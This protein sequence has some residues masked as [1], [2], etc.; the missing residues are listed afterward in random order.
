MYKN[1]CIIFTLFLFFNLSDG[2]R[3]SRT[4]NTPRWAMGYGGALFT[5]G[6][7]IRVGAGMF[8]SDYGY[9]IF[10]P[11]T[12][13]WTF[14]AR[15]GFGDHTTSILLPNGKLLHTTTGGTMYLYEPTTDIWTTSGASYS[16][17]PKNPVT[18]LKDGRILLTGTNSYLYNYIGDNVSATAS[19][20]DV[21]MGTETLLP[22]DNVLVVIGTTAKLYSPTAGTWTNTASPLVGRTYH[23]AV[24]L[25]PPYSKVL[26]ISG[27][28]A[29]TS[30]TLYD[31]VTGTWGATG[32]LNYGA[33]VVSETVLLP[34]GKVLIISSDSTNGGGPGS[35]KTCELFD[36]A[37]GTSGTWSMTDSL[38][39]PIY[40]FGGASHSTAFILQTG[41]VLLAGCG[42]G[43]VQ[44]PPKA[45]LIYDPS[46]AVFR[47]RPVLNYA[48]DA[49]TTTPL[50]I[51]HTNNCSTNVLI[52]GGENSSGT[53]NKCELYNY[54]KRTAQFTGDLNTA[55][56][57]HIAALLPSGLVFIA[58]GK[59][60]SGTLN[61][62]ESYDVNT[63]LWTTAASMTESRFDHTGTLVNDGKVL[64]TGGESGGSYLTSCE[65][66]DG[67]N[68]SATGGLGT[69]RSRHTA[70]LL[71]N[72][73]VLVVGG[74]TTGDAATNSCELWNGTNWSP[75]GNLTNSR[76]W[77]TALLL[78]SG[79][80]LV[81]GGTSDGTNGLTSCEI[82]DPASGTWS[83]EANL[84]QARYMHN[85]TLLYSGLVLT[86]GGKDGSNYL[87]ECEIWDP[88]AELD[89][90]TNTHR[91]KL[92]ASLSYG[93]A[94]HSSVLVPD[95]QPYILAIGGN[96]GSYMGSIEEYDIGLEYNNAWQSTITNYTSTV[97]IS[98]SMAIEGTLF[99]GVSEADGGNYC[100]IANNDHPIMSF[101]RVGGGNWQSNGGGDI[102]Y[103][104]HSTS[105]S[106]THTTVTMPANFAQ[107]YYRMWAIVNGIPT[108]WYEDC[109][110]GIEEDS[111]AGAQKTEIGIYPNPF[112]GKAVIRYSG[113]FDK[114]INGLAVYDISGKK[115][116]E[117][118]P[119]NKSNSGQFVLSVDDK[120]MPAGIYFLSVTG[121][122][123]HYKPVKFI[124]L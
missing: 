83:A 121:G 35:Y 10:N 120:K 3:W 8:S 55:R 113:I 36:P 1:I 117:F 67:T 80:V 31:P 57:H 85:S 34:S 18:L 73:N 106:D 101:V 38:I 94:Y 75:T 11:A 110:T 47:T 109:A 122:A 108:K 51:V 28:N 29:G 81:V 22:N 65:T 63:E 40:N 123:A 14:T 43:T 82:Y 119:D 74:Q 15:S 91:W 103:V 116:A 37:G 41:K 124:K 115:I 53:L 2:G 39:F 70:T 33:R 30:C 92:T 4:G 54:R 27:Y 98:S 21:D 25:P 77:H 93:R 44:N 107:G 76:Y 102:M 56:S 7:A 24:L 59:N 97:P 68:W 16:A 58:G 60:T 46:N 111:K 62:C 86:T 95:I 112:R 12:G 118:I 64:V 26:V 78:Q 72:G 42:K 87:T 71:L 13:T 61:S 17:V 89:T 45:T 5:D 52:V 96:N 88:A 20:G 69:P 105:W 49:H 84:N 114:G 79:K 99:R 32:V 23:T 6:R 19:S 66:F 9:D 90:T 104:P 48:R 50:P 100:H